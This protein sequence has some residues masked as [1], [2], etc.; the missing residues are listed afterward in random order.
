MKKITLSLLMTCFAFL[1]N[2]QWQA[3]GTVL[4]S[5]FTMK[6]MNN[7]NYDLFTILNSGKHLLIDFSATW[8]GP[9]WSYHTTHV[10]DKY[11]DKYGPTGTAVK[12]AQVILYET[13]P[14]TTTADVQGTTSGTQGN[15]TTG[16]THPICN[17]TSTSNV[18]SKFLAPGTTSYGV[19]A[20]FV[21]CKNK[22]LYK[23]S[24]SLT[25][26]TGLRSYIAGKCGIFPLSSED[27]MDIDFSYNLYPNPSA[28][29]STIHVSL[30]K[31]NT[32]SYTVTNSL[33]QV[34]NSM[35]KTN[36]LE[37]TKDIELNTSSWSNG[38]YFVN[39][40]VGARNVN[41]KL[42]VAH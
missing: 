20:V 5:T 9:C 27:V 22:K 13:D 1:S 31:S 33:G 39:L 10:M 26:E 14:S 41:A 42:V 23:I 12:D 37:G 30:D 21:V 3:D 17:E 15:W 24:T 28:S 7:V 4:T 18:I 34:V 40:T 29:N 16:T 36:M 19:P 25:T 11:H 32:V 38:V 6:D 2:A 8:C 35:P